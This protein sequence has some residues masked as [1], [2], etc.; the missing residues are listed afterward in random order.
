MYLYSFGVFV[1]A[2]VAVFYILAEAEAMLT[3]TTPPQAVVATAVAAAAT[4]DSGGSAA[5]GVD[6][7]DRI[8]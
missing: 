3:M 1:E 5:A 8:A 4:D 2:A 6:G 7:A